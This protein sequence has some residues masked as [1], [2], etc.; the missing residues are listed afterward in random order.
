MRRVIPV[1]VFLATVF[2]GDWLIS[3]V[4]RGLVERSQNPIVRMLRGEQ[5]SD[6][7]FLGDSRIDRNID[8][9]H[10]QARTGLRPL[11]LGLGGNS[12]VVSEALLRDYLDRYGPPT[13]VVVEL[14]QTT[15]DPQSMGEMRV[16]ACLSTN[17]LGVAC[18]VDPWYSRGERV[19][20][21]LRFND[22]SF[23]RLAAEAL[24]PPTP[25][26]LTNRIPAVVVREWSGERRVDR[27]LYPENFAALRR[28]CELADQHHFRLALIIGPCWPG[29]RRA[30]VNFA[31]WRDALQS[32]AGSR[33]LADYSLCFG[34]EA[35]V[36]NDEL[37]LNAQGAVRFVDRL[38]ADGWLAGDAARREL[39]ANSATR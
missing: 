16:L 9:A 35:D 30:I 34:E 23:W 8:F 11:N 24:Q 7:V 18:A 36:Y 17:L 22:A 5:P 21:T 6:V 29:Y 4:A 39:P 27:P 26:T 1:A 37:H 12:M 2:A 3:R 33:P 14:G 25:R 31:G 38:L 10:V 19:F 20:G 15:V 13:A 28:I 32:V